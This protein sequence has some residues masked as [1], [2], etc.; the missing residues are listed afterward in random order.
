[1]RLDFTTCSYLGLRHRAD[2]LGPWSAI[3]EARPA[4]LQEA[5]LLT[6]LGRA[7]AQLQG[8][9]DG[10]AGPSSLTLAMDALGPALGDGRACSWRVLVDAGCY[11]VLLWAAAQ[12]GPPVSIA[13]HRPPALARV[14]ADL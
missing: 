11:P 14:L 12:G 7:V 4:A 9:E 10:V 13:H 5:P 8:E 2:R 1:M 6:W 3:A